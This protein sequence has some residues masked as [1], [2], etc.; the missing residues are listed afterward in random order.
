LYVHKDRQRIGVGAALLNEIE[1]KA[2]EQGNHEIY[3]HVS[4][5]A[6]GLFEKHGYIHKEDLRDIYKGVLFINA[7]MLKKLK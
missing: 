5:T 2:L 3:S 6:K 1:R 4:R 7:L